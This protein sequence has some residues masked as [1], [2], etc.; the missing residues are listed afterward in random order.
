MNRVLI[1]EANILLDSCIVALDSLKDASE[2]EAVC[3]MIKEADNLL[4]K[5]QASA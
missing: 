5:A 2:I 1:D 3:D 4:A